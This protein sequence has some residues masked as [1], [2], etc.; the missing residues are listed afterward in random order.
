MAK[1]FSDQRGATFGFGLKA[2]NDTGTI[3]KV[4]GV[5][6]AKRRKLVNTSIHNLNR[7][8]SVGFTNDKLFI[9]E[10]Q[11]LEAALRK[12]IINKSSGIMN[13]AVPSDLRKFSKSVEELKEIKIEWKKKNQTP[14]EGNILRKKER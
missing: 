7:E 12:M 14:L 10:K 1:S 13:Y 4:E 8:Q 5:T 2:K 9:C 11:Y 6:K 3:L